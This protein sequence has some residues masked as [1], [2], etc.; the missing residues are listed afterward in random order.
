MK[1]RTSASDDADRILGHPVS[2]RAFLG[3]GLAGGVALATP[4]SVMNTLLEAGAKGSSGRRSINSL[5]MAEQPGSIETF[6]PGRTGEIDEAPIVGLCYDG[7]T[8]FSGSKVVPAYATSWHVSE[9]GLTYTFNLNPNWKFSTGDTVTPEDYIFSVYR[10]VNGKAPSSWMMSDVVSLKQTGPQQ[11][12]YRLKA[13]SP[14][15]LKILPNRSFSVSDAKVVKDHGGTDAANAAT[16]DT[17]T[18]WLNQHSVGTGPFQIQSWEVGSR[19]LLTANPYYY[20]HKTV[21][22]V[23]IQF[24]PDVQTQLDLLTGGSVDVVFN[25]TSHTAADLLS[26]PSKVHVALASL[27]SLGFAYLGFNVKGNNPINQPKGWEAVRYA[28]DYEGMLKL[29]GSAGRPVGSVIPPELPNALPASQAIKQDI[30]RAKAALA[31]LGKPDGFSFTLTYASD[32]I[33]QSVPATEVAQ[34]IVADLAKIGVNAKLSGMPLTEELTQSRAG[35]L[36]ADLHFWGSDYPGWTDYLPTYAPGGS[37]ASARQHYMPDQSPQAKR[38]AELTAKALSTTDPAAQVGPCQ[39]AQR[40][41]NENGPYAWLFEPNYMFGY[42]TDVFS[43]L[44]LNYST[45]INVED[46]PLV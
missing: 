21:D 19:V 34:K 22:L 17:A 7:L 45:F 38:I 43:H 20:G 16:T 36:E 41:L 39:E 37:V 13:L 9:D 18:P 31:A 35:T 40:L 8:Q 3:G 30:P 28:L 11:V 25:L 10:E 15:F 26:A 23:V 27:P 5:V 24:V 46:S 14:D 2:R 32:Q 4:R 12:T 33:I 29:A 42:R 6:D 1:G 44:D